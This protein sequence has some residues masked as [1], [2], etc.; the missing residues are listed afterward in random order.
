MHSHRRVFVPMAGLTALFGA[1]R[2]VGGGTTGLAIAI[3]LAAAA[4]APHAQ[5]NAFAT[6]HSP[7]H[8]GSSRR[9]PTAKRLARPTALAPRATTLTPRGLRAA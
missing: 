9:T 1:F 8:A 5:P 7:E 3:A 6:G 2:S 4:V